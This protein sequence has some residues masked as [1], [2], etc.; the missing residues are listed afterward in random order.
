MDQQH[1][2]A[3]GS[4]VLVAPRI[5]GNDDRPKIT[6]AFGQDVFVAWRA[7]AVAA[8]LQE[9]GFDQRAE[10]AREHVRRDPETFLELVEAC[11][12]VEGVAENQDAPPL[13]DPLQGAGDRAGHS[14][15][16]LAFH[17]THFSL[18]TIM[19]QVAK[20]G[21]SDLLHL[22]DL[23]VGQR[24]ISGTHTID[25]TQIRAFAREFDPQPFH[26]DDDAARQTL[27][28]GLAA[29]GWHTA[30]ITMRLLVESGL[31]VAGGIVGA[32]GEL[33][34]PRPTRPGDVLHVESEVVEVIPSRSRPDRGTATVR[35]E[36]RNQNG[37]IV[38][39][40]T[41]KLIVPRRV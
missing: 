31:P 38:Q 18:V 22:D 30:A 28:A 14:A 34:W 11:V 21:I 5:H 27:F 40:F 13:T 32:G 37:D 20:S 9:P 29:S 15:E 35:S 6:P 17:L 39:V 23:R 26:L 1:A 12:S 36:T 16:A 25:E 33:T 3:L 4:K 7:L 8:P 19:M 24:F 41:A 2:L 10:P